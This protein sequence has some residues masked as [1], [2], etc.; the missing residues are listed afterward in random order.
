[1]IRNI[2]ER[3]HDP[4][5]ED[6][7]RR[8]E[9]MKQDMASGKIPLYQP[10][11]PWPV[12]KRVLFLIALFLVLMVLASVFDNGKGSHDHYGPYDNPQVTPDDYD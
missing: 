7:D 2:H 10:P 12:W 9:Q 6:F 11:Q 8:L 3:H 5:I 1:M 4:E